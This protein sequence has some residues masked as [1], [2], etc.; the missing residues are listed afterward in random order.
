[1]PYGEEQL[2]L[3]TG[4]HQRYILPFDRP[5]MHTGT[6]VV[7]GP[8][9][10]GSSNLHSPYTLVTDETGS[11]GLLTQRLSSTTSGNA[12]TRFFP[13]GRL[14]VV[15]ER[16]LGRTL[17]LANSLAG[18]LSSTSK[19]PVALSTWPL[20]PLSFSCWS[21]NSKGRISPLGVG[22]HHPQRTTVTHA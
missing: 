8:L 5:L 12:Y 11:D 22:I 4:C 14:F 9:H 20:I 18:S 13:A 10:P 1:M 7:S 17:V 19:R 3:C 16:C 2:W 15:V 21:T 6:C